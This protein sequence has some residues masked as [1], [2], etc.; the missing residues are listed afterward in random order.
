MPEKRAKILK[1]FSAKRIIWPVLIGVGGLFGYM[2]YKDF[3]IN[4]FDKISWTWTTSIFIF[5][6]LLMMVVRHFAYM[7]R[8]RV[9][10]DKEL[11][12]WQCF[13]VI[14]LWEFASA[15][16][17][18]IVGGTTFA[19]FLLYKE[20]VSAGRSTTIVLFT[21]FLDELFFM[22]IAPIFFLIVGTNVIFPNFE[23]NEL[24]SLSNGFFYAFVVGYSALLVYTLLLAYGLLVNPKGFKKMLVKI[25]SIKLLRR[26][27]DGIEKTSDDIVTASEN[28]QHEDL[29][30]WIKTF[31]AT[32]ASWSARFLVVNFMLLAFAS[33]AG[34]DQII[35]FA[36]QIVMW[37]IMLV[38]PTPG[39]SGMAEVAFEA[40]LIDYTPQ[41]LALAMALLW[42]ILSYYP[43]LFLGVLVLPRW[44][45]RVYTLN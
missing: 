8:I 41:G 15:A 5:I 39:S 43:Y 4:A 19:L 1:K 29:N 32:L 14:M 35:I 13:D 12:W 9:L 17:P 44:I 24:I 36:R 2:F 26:W 45:K 34:Y 30:F 18:S 20:K 42:R 28:L 10:V 22:L 33:I 37:V 7:Y 16:T 21:A 6:A 3:D 38:T 11:S 25:F 23:N 31:G 27:K 40:F